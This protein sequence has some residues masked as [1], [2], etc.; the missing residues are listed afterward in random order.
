MIKTITALEA[1]ESR[2]LG[3][4][5][6]VGTWS[7]GCRMVKVRGQF[8]EVPG[9]KRAECFQKNEAGITRKGDEMCLI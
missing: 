1:G 7:R 5:G 9:A 2:V 6:P 3:M 4:P 8:Q